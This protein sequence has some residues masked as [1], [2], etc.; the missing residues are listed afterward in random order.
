M[1]N[2]S[3]W[4]PRLVSMD[5]CLGSFRLIEMLHSELCRLSRLMLMQAVIDR[6]NAER[7]KGGP[8]GPP[9]AGP[10]GPPGPPGPQSQMPAMPKQCG[11]LVSRIDADPARVR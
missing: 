4:G 7:Q 3:G 1:N 2:S 11:H 5:E 9:G 8:P 10:P 6:E